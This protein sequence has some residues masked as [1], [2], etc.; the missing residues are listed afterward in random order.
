MAKGK[1]SSKSDQNYWAKYKSSEIWKINRLR[2]LTRALKRSP[3]N[4]QILL[5]MKNIKYRRKTPKE[6]FWTSNKILTAKL[7]KQFTGQV[8]KD[9]FNSNEKIQAEAL[10][11]SKSKNTSIV[12]VNQTSRVSYSI[13]SRAHDGQGNLVWS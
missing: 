1:T 11:N 2:K 4:K 7:F 5:A 10:L 12:L 9:I 3:G 8:N 13:A 6:P